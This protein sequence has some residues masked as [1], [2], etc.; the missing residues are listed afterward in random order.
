MV[1]APAAG[2]KL[3]AQ[4]LDD[5]PVCSVMYELQEQQHHKPPSSQAM[6]GDALVSMALEHACTAGAL[7]NTGPPLPELQLASPGSTLGAQLLV[8]RQQLERYRRGGSDTNYTLDGTLSAESMA[9]LRHAFVLLAGMQ[10]QHNPLSSTLFMQTQC[11]AM[12]AQP[13]MLVPVLSSTSQRFC[14]RYHY[15]Q[16]AMDHAQRCQRGSC[17]TC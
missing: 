14:C 11:K 6:R 4:Y 7:C 8:A 5:R 16:V 3:I 10:R 2:R 1:L 12:H 9:L 17:V 15:H 13:A